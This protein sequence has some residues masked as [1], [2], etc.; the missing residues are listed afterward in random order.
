MRGCG[1][2]K[3]TMPLGDSARAAV[4]RT[5]AFGLFTRFNEAFWDEETGF[6]AFALDGEKKKVLSVASNPGHCL[7]SGI[8][9]PERAG[10]CRGAADAAGHVERVGHPHT[11]GGP[12]RLQPVFL[13]ERLGL[14][15]RQRSHCAGIQAL[16]SMP[17]R[18]GRSQTTYAQ[19]R[20]LFHAESASGSLC[21]LASGCG[22]FSRSISGR[23]CAAGLGC[24]IGLLAAAGDPWPAAGCAARRC[25][26]STLY[27]RRGSAM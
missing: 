22:E 10:T 23:Q 24:R 13:P 21:G 20:V 27:C 19:S 15:A 25:S 3:S 2:R 7:W 17:R 16:W 6:Y 18:R 8:V 14:A 12:S 1:W 5:K 4:L 26:M 9:P 11:V